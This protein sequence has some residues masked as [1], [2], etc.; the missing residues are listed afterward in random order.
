MTITRMVGQSVK[1]MLPGDRLGSVTV[2]FVRGDRVRLAIDLPTE[3][4]IVREELME[5]WEKKG[6]E[7]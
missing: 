4:P 3:I 2:K 5:K 1:F 6:E 7:S